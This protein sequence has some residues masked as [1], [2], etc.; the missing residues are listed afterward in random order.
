MVSTSAIGDTLLHGATYYDISY[1]D[2]PGHLIHLYKEK[3][4][5]AIS[6]SAF[7]INADTL[8]MNSLKQGKQ[9]KFVRL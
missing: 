7:G 3:G 8:F 6:S 1:A 4:S 2:Y 5:T 9:F